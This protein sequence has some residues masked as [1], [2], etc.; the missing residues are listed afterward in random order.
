MLHI[1]LTTNSP[2]EAFRLYFTIK[3]IQA[4][5]LSWT[6]LWPTNE[7]VIT[8]LNIEL[9][10]ALQSFPGAKHLSASPSFFICEQ[11]SLKS[12]RSC[13]VQ[14]II[15]MQDNSSSY[16]SIWTK[17]CKKHGIDR[18][19]KNQVWWHWW[20]MYNNMPYASSRNS[21]ALPVGGAGYH[22]AFL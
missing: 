13:W 11:F 19:L 17:V 16:S 8:V 1:R 3:F 18:G 9:V 12:Y 10:W 22:T 20:Q 7:Q 21:L 6:F 4:I 15:V 14:L 2:T 5:Q